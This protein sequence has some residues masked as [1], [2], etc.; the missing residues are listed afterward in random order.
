V[1]AEPAGGLFLA[2][3]QIE[4]PLEDVMADVGQARPDT[5]E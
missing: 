3:A 2:R 1:D 4:A 5:L